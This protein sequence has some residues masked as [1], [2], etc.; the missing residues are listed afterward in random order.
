[1]N[2]HHHRQERTEHHHRQEHD[3]YV[4]TAGE[5]PNHR[6]NKHKH[7]GYI[8]WTPHP[9]PV[10]V[11]PARHPGY[12]EADINARL[13]ARRLKTSNEADPYTSRSR[14]HAMVGLILQDMPQR[15][16]QYTKPVDDL[17]DTVAYGR[18]SF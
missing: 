2:V 16:D 13:Y 3:P 9:T 17:R 14:R 5:L 12:W 18:G 15:Q 8:S 4:R 11:A 10:E 6:P 1:M 7:E